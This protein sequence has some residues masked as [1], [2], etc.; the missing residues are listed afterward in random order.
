MGRHPG[1]LAAPTGRELG[2]HV[3]WTYAS[4]D[5]H[6]RVLTTYLAEG[7]DAGQRVAYFAPRRQADRIITY[8]EEAGRDVG[9]LLVERRLVIGSAEEAYTPDGEFDADS[10]L[11]AYRATVHEAIADG[12]NGFRVA[13]EAAWLVDHPMHGAL[14]PAYELRADLLASR[15]PFIAMCCYDLRDCTERGLTLVQAVHGRALQLK[16]SGSMFHV[17]AVRGGAL[18]IEGELD[19]TCADDLRVLVLAAVQD[20]NEPRLDVSALRF[21]DLTGMRT[22]A[23]L[24]DALRDAHGD[25]SIFGASETFRSVWRAMDYD[26][27]ALTLSSI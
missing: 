6:R 11:A 1:M 25:V 9:E 20:I 21:T 2:D 15:E 27:G 13:A 22:I 24:V 14:W 5:A 16:V 3:C 4:D 7:L 19:S 12:Y 8:L 26:E 10:R 18:K 17:H 23:A